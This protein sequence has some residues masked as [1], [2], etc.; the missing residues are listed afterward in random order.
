MFTAFGNC[1]L[2]Y[3]LTGILGAPVHFTDE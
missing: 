2:F 1:A 3:T